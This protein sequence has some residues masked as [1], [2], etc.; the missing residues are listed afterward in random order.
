[1]SEYSDKYGPHAALGRTLVQWSQASR[2]PLVLLIDEIDTL[3]GDTPISVLHQLRTRYDMRPGGFPQSVILCG[4]RDVRDCQIYSSR[5]GA[6]VKGGSAF[7]IKAESLRLGDGR[8]SDRLGRLQSAH[9]KRTQESPEPIF[10]PIPL[11][12]WTL[13]V[14]LPCLTA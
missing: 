1:M 3:V 11:A 7:N 6:N 13:P 10:E 4:V 2:L 8:E 9:R 14:W 12:L 5:E